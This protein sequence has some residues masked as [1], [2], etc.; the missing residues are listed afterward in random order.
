MSKEELSQYYE[1]TTNGYKR[2][3]YKE[4][5]DGLQRDIEEL[6]KKLNISVEIIN[7]KQNEIKRLNNKLVKIRYL[8]DR[9]PRQT[10]KEKAYIMLKS[11]IAEVIGDDKNANR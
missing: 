11:E 4:V 10:S 5:I 6:N 8:I 2:L 7:K 9:T 3:T 1:E